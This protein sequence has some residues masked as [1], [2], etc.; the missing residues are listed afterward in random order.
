MPQQLTLNVHLNDDATF[1][2]YYCLPGSHRESVIKSIYTLIENHRE[3]Y[4]YL[5]G[6]EGCGRSHLLQ[7]ACHVA[8][9]RNLQS[10]YLPL[11]ELKG[12]DPDALFDSLEE[13]T[14]LCIDDVHTVLTDNIWEEALFHLFNRVK[15]NNNKLLVAGDT[16]PGN[17]TCVLADLHSRLAWGPVFQLETYSDEIKQSILQYRAQNRGLQLND[18]AARFILQHSK[19]TMTDLMSLLTQLDEHSLTNKKRLTIPF[20][21]KTLVL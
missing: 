12:V 21:K 18:D 16:A 9:D 8:S 20:I 2:N 11:S 6:S 3:H 14:L 7:A 1:D 4:L 15:A 10:Q 19:R 13:I 5:W 17:L